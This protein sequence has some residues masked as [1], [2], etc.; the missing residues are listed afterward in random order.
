[1]VCPRQAAWCRGVPLCIWRSVGAVSPACACCS[2]R[3]R[4]R[5]KKRW[6]CSFARETSGPLWLWRPFHESIA[7]GH[8]VR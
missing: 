6:N 8:H 2:A 4:R 7:P 1:L 3:A 5:R